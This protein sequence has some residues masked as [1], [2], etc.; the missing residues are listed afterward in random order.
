[1]R[2][3]SLVHPEGPLT[4]LLLSV[5]MGTHGLILGLPPQPGLPLAGSLLQAHRPSGTRAHTPAM[6]PPRAPSVCLL[7]GC[8]VPTTPSPQQHMFPGQRSALCLARAHHHDLLSP[9]LKARC[10]ELKLDWSTLSLENLLKEKQ[11]LRSQISEKQRHCLELQVGAAAIAGAPIRASMAVAGTWPMPSADPQEPFC[12]QGRGIG[13]GLAV[14]AAWASLSGL[15]GSDGLSIGGAPLRPE[16]LGPHS[17]PRIASVL[18]A[19]SFL[20]P[21]LRGSVLE[22]QG[23][24]AWAFCEKSNVFAKV[25]RETGREGRGNGQVCLVLRFPR[26]G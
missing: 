9:Q 6:S 23:L 16:C 1:M 17:K 11:A 18:P 4:L 3:P 10:E 14:T 22:H 12:S 26:A 21:P 15:E 24:T 5:L 20:K 13:F 25:C 19:E 2:P 8:R 7:P